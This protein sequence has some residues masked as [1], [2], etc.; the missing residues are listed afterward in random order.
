MSHNRATHDIQFYL[1]NALLIIA[2]IFAGF[3]RFY[4]LDQIPPGFTFDEASHALDA[5]DILNGQFMLISPRLQETPA[6]YMYF[7][8]GAFKLFEAT[9]LAQRSVSA[10]FGVLMIPVNFFAVREWFKEEGKPKAAWI[11]LFSSL[12]LST[13]FWAVI[14]G[15]KGF[16]Y[17]VPPVFALTAVYFF[18]QG[19]QRPRWGLVLTAALFRGLGFY[20]YNGAAAFLPAL[21]VA[22]F[23]KLLQQRF[24]P[25][26][27]PSMPRVTWQLFVVFTLSLTLL[28]LP[29]FL[30]LT[31]GETPEVERSVRMMVFNQAETLFGGIQLL[32]RNILAYAQSFMALGGDHRWYSNLPGR[33]VLNPALA[34]SFLAGGLISLKR[35]KQLSYLFL[36]LFW[37]CSVTPSALTIAGTTISAFNFRMS[38]ALPATYV[39]IAVAWI[40]LY[41][42][43]KTKLSARPQ[44]ILQ[45][46]AASLAMAPFLLMTLVWL[47]FETYQDYFVKWANHP[48]VAE[49]HDAPIVDLAYWMAQ[50]TN[51]EAI[52]LLPRDAREVRSNY[53]LDFL[54]QGQAPLKYVIL[55]DQTIRQT[56]SK[57][58]SNYRKIHLITKL[59]GGR[60]RL[61]RRALADPLIPVLLKKYGEFQGEQQTKY[62]RIETY[63]LNSKRT[64]F[65]AHLDKEVP[66]DFQPLSLIVGEEVKLAGIKRRVEGANLVIDLAWQGW[67]KPSDVAADFTVFVQLLNSEGRRIA[68]V[69]VRPEPGFTQL[70]RSE[71]M[72]AH[73]VI[74]LSEDIAHNDYRI[75]IG[76]YYFDENQQVVNVGAVTLPTPVI[77]H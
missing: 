5:L 51:P 44:K 53:T 9:P 17:I 50:E 74:P 71:I 14:T 34:L 60:E 48:E 39:L 64:N 16:E 77:P 12:L 75:Y 73:Y 37:I 76:L 15:R 68:G 8:A 55:S 65:L 13:S 41:G 49:A 20:M 22:L 25:A 72:L 30:R 40:E 21:P 24:W 43:L 67:L 52:F 42:W 32:F 19:Y 56:L 1:I 57:E 3:F 66:A 38:G 47:P 58:L 7:V 4:K 59:E 54:Y 18:W 45:T 2:V 69:D 62:Y 36:L 27:T 11:A 29:I 46:S 10:A 26:K 33:P 23:L 28:T 61:Q 63:L 35:I 70:D 31:G 6:G